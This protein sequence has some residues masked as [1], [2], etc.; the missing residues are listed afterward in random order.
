[1]PAFHWKQSCAAL[2]RPS[3]NG[4]VAPDERAKST[5]SGYCAQEVLASAEEMKDA[6]VGALRR[7]KATPAWTFRQ[8]QSSSGRMRTQLER[9]AT[10]R[11]AANVAQGNRYNAAQPGDRCRQGSRRQMEDLERR[12]TVAK[13]K[14]F[15]A[16]LAPTPDDTPPGAQRGRPRS[17]ALSQQDDRAADRAASQAVRAEA[18]AGAVPRATVELVLHV[19]ES[20]NR[21]FTRVSRINLN[22]FNLHRANAVPHIAVGSANRILKRNPR[23]SA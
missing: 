16:L 7:R 15:A 14:L 4:S 5:V 11:P 12:L 18:T 20:R 19:A 3:T 2:T 17:R 10:S 6:A 21:G 9:D 23:S 1:M 13:E 22:V 8:L